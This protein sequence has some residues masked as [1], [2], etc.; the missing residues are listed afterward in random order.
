MKSA[1]K[2]QFDAMYFYF[3]YYLQIKKQSSVIQV[4]LIVN[5]LSNHIAK[6]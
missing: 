4:K 2:V 1:F 3:L 5:L 6:Y